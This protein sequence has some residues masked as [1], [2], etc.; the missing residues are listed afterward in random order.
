MLRPDGYVKVLDFGIAKL[1]ES[2]F[3]EATAD[4]AESLTL[5]E[6]NL[7]SILGTV[8]Y[9]SP[10]QACGAQVDKSTDIWSLGVVLYEMVTGH[11]PFTGDT[12]KEVMSAI[13]EKEPPPL[14]NYI[15]Q[16]PAELQQI[17][18]KTLRKDREQRYHSAHELLQA[19]KDLRHKLEV[20]ADLA[21]ATAA[22]L[23]LRWI[24]SP[25]ALVLVLLVAAL[26]LALPFYWHRNLHDELATREKHRRAA[27]PRS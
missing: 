19:L 10:E 5:A 27:I 8:R 24:R 17:I 18:S 11:A 20:E 25:A 15:A 14:T 16:P 3:A 26:A 12:P 23:W 2:A 7:G 21:R 13:L 22:P 6:T 4:G 1:A 9:M